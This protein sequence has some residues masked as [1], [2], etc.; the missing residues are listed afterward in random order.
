MSPTL[1]RILLCLLA[2][3]VSWVCA[4]A[5]SQQRIRLPRP[6][7]RL[8]QPTITVPQMSMWLEGTAEDHQ[9]TPLDLPG[10]PNQDKLLTRVS[11]ETWAPWSAPFPVQRATDPSTRGP[12][13]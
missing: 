10:G 9:F 5:L 4:C 13:A 11:L 7:H 1:R 6:Y 8:S 2:I 12:P 3:N